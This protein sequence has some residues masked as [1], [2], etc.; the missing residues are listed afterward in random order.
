MNLELE[1]HLRAIT[2]G[3]RRGDKGTGVNGREGRRVPE[4]GQRLMDRLMVIR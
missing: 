4:V 2:A 3:Q 1:N